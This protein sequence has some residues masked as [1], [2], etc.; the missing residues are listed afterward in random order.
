[1]VSIAAQA[2]LRLIGWTFLPDMGSRIAL[3]LY[4]HARQHLLP[5]LGF[6]SV[7][8]PPP[9]S[10]DDRAQQQTS[11]AL[12]V[13]VYLMWN[14]AQ[15]YANTQPS[16]YSLLDVRPNADDATLRTAFRNFAR[17]NHPDIIGPQG[18]PRFIATREAFDALKSH[19]V[20]FAYDRFGPEVTK[21]ANECE[22]VT[23]YLH[24][25]LLGSVGYYLFTSV[26]M[27]FYAVFGSSG[28]GAYVSLVN[29]CNLILIN[30]PS[31]IVEKQSI[32]RHD[33]R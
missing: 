8:P 5:Q 17:Y 21:W 4:R 16:F 7:P 28:F 3:K 22:T 10:I 24:R 31:L 13:L 25:G 20:R 27:L 6:K 33:C 18:E 14:T 29:L 11:F 12:V 9:K 30:L 32:S 1:M 2:T 19:T 15:S 23:D 26:A